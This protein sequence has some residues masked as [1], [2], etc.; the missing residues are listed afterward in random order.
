MRCVKCG[1]ALGATPAATVQTRQ[2][3]SAWGPVCARRA[4]L[5]SPKRRERALPLRTVRA[6][7]AAD[8]EQLPL[9][10]AA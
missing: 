2:G 5:I 9:E 3:L 7:T 8:D 6:T 4:G 10:F 1:R